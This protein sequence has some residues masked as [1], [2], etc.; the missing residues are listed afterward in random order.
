MKN[1][2]MHSVK[3]F[4]V[5]YQVNERTVR[6]WIKSGNLKA[7]GIES[8]KIGGTIRIIEPSSYETLSG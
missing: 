1:L 2:N 4:A 7:L 6:N 5:R 3:D 8:V